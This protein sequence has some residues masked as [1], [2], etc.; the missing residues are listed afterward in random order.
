MHEMNNLYA[1]FHVAPTYCVITNS[2]KFCQ[3]QLLLAPDS[4]CKFFAY[5]GQE[6]KL[7]NA[8]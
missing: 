4:D 6:K 3:P 5:L 7:K 2:E 8:Q 1:V